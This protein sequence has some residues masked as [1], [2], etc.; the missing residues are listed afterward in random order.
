[1]PS[2]KQQLSTALNQFYNQPI[3]RVSFE[4]LLSVGAVMFFAIFAIRPTLLTM[5]DLIKEIEDKRKLDTEL[6]QKIAALSTAQSEFLAL[7]DQLHVLD[8]ALPNQPQL[9]QSLKIIEKVAS[10]QNLTIISM[11]IPEIPPETEVATNTP[12]SKLTRQN[13]PLGVTVSGTY[14]EMREFVEQLR[15][16]RRSFIIDSVSFSVSQEKSTKQ[17]RANV[18]FS[19]PYFSEGSGDL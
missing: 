5:S 6:T 14:P 17:L 4:L 3:A 16:V 15:R 8:Q 19:I 12:A 11:T 9:L 7:Q 10:E 18:T 2:T 13:I 1:M